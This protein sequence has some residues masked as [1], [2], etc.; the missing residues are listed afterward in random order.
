MCACLAYIFGIYANYS[1]E[2]FK[3][4]DKLSIYFRAFY[5]DENDSKIFSVKFLI[6]MRRFKLK[7]KKIRKLKLFFF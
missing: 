3:T 7:Y 6:S 2:E 4:R 1:S 5:I